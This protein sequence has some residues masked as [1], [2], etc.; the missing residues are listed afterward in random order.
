[1]VK[2][3]RNKQIYYKNNNYNEKNNKIALKITNIN[4][5]YLVI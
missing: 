3:Y 1:M 5:G 2:F 4:I